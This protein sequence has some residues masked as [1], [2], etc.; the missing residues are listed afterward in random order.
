[1]NYLFNRVLI[2]DGS[3]MLHRA[4]S[5]PHNWEMS[6]ING[7]KT[8]GIFG[9]LRILN[10]ELRSYNYYPIVIFDAGLSKRR[11][12]LYSNY[13]K[14]DDKAVLLEDSHEF[15]D[16]ELIDLEFRREYNTQRNDLKVILPL[17]GIPVL[18]IEG[19]EGDDL[20]YILSK[21]TKNSIVVS[22]D[23]DLIQLIHNQSE[24]DDRLCRVRRPLRDEFLDINSLN[25][26]GIN[27][28]EYIGCKSIVGDPSD[29]IPS[30]CYQVGEK[31][32]LGL[33]K[34]YINCMANNIAFPENEEALTESCKKF[35]ISKR[36]A[37]L[38]FNENQFLINLLLTDL[39]QVDKEI[40][41][42]L[43]QSIYIDIINQFE[44]NQDGQSIKE[45]FDELEIK[46]FNINELL[47][48]VNSLKNTL[49]IEDSNKVQSLKD[50]KEPRKT[51]F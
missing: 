19:W 30:A 8:G 36:K 47:D 14:H 27:I 1:M 49:K 42:D 50:I 25:E 5:E 45:I 46:T 48:T 34:L 21:L 31:T 39:Q 37:Y 12:D 32:A 24:D 26:K 18:S 40:S 23:K 38:N 22:D 29:N 10:K 2:F 16:E 4:L 20:I 33:Y 3:Y 51:L 44:S 15:T 11:L 13:K 6:T 9:S 41:D 43:I 17:F 7:K 28:K 35:N